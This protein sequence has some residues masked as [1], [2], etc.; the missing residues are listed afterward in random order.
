MVLPQLGHDADGQVRGE[1]VKCV[2]GRGA[3]EIPPC[4][5]GHSLKIGA[6]AGVRLGLFAAGH[7]SLMNVVPSAVIG[8]TA[9]CG[10]RA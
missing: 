10:V 8:P 1:R 5:D 7:L 3:H 9:L 4:G 2:A 6:C